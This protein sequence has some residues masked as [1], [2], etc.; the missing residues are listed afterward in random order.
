M[1]WCPSHP[2]KRVD[3]R[4]VT[5]ASE[6]SPSSPIKNDQLGA[7]HNGHDHRP[8]WGRRGGYGAERLRKAYSNRTYEINPQRS[9][10]VD[11]FPKPS[12]VYSTHMR[13]ERR[14][15]VR[16]RAGR[17]APR[18]GVFRTPSTTI[19]CAWCWANPDYADLSWCELRRMEG[20]ELLNGI[21][22]LAQLRR[23]SESS[24]LDLG[25]RYR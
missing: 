14:H 21:T 9:A 20:S 17:N 23:M 11:Q 4:T 8:A 10:T 22:V 3:R 1:A 6:E 19:P 13:E 24:R 5:V 25:F 16:V 12:H 2:C 18:F 15:V 7:V